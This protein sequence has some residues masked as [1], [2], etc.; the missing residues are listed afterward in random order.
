[1]ARFEVEKIVNRFAEASGAEFK[2]INNDVVSL[3]GVL[4]VL[5]N[6]LRIENGKPSR[7]QFT[8]DIINAKIIETKRLLTI[9]KTRNNIK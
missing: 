1:M 5:Y 2:K 8:I 7:H 4:T 6:E 3:E 9:A